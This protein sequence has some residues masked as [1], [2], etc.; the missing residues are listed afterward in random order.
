M[1]RRYGFTLIELLVVIAII[2]ILAAILFPVFAK[3]RE[4]ARQASCQS[5]LKQVGLAIAQ[6]MQ[7]YDE[8]YPYAGNGTDDPYVAV[9]VCGWRGWLSNVVMPY[10][11]NNQLFVCPS[12]GN[13]YYNVGTTTVP[14]GDSRFYK[15]S[16][17]YNY[18]AAINSTT[19][20]STNVPGAGGAMGATVRP[21]EL[22]MVWDS[23]NRWADGT[24]AFGRDV[25]QAFAGNDNYGQ[26]HNAL[27]NFLYADG[28]VKT[29]K[30]SQLRYRNLTNM[31]ESDA[32]VDRPVGPTWVYP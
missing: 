25:A 15:V 11:K 21:A 32:T 29:N 27:A 2:A 5:N 28:H 1:S 7:D 4:K 3:A 10:V 9:N 26:R 31:P 8:K 13:N 30:F 18:A 14:T 20:S 23:A 17:C 22:C 24:N 16:Y 6:Y 12:D 19:P